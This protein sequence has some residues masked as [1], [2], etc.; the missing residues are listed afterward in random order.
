MVKLK[1]RSETIKNIRV[2]G[3]LF[4]V[5]FFIIGFRGYSLQILSA[6]KLSKIIKRQTERNIELSP[7]RGTIYD[8]NGSELS[9]SIDV[10]SL[11]ANPHLIDNKGLTAIK[12]SRIL[13]ISHKTILKNFKKNR[14]FVWIKRQIS[15]AEASKIKKLGINGLEFVAE[16]QRFYPNKELGAQMIGFVG[17]DPKGL[18]GI[19]YEY[20]DVLKGKSRYLAINRDALGR[21]L[22]IDGAK[23]SEEVQ[24]NDITLTIDKNIQ[25]IAEKELQAAISISKAKS[26]IA[27]VMEPATGK[28]LAMA[29]APLFNPNQYKKY[30]PKTWRNRAITD[31]FEP[32]STFKTFLMASALEE[33]I[34]KPKDIFFCENGSF[35]VANRVIHDTHPHGWL[36][37]TKILKYSSNIG[38]SKIARH[39]GSELFY[40]HIREFGFGEETGIA[41]PSEANG[42]IPLPYRTSEH[43]RSAMAFGQG[44]SVSPLQL[45][46]AYSA[47][48]NGGL[49]M[50]PYFVEKITHPNGMT[51]QETKPQILRRVVTEKTARTVRNML[52]TVVSK[53]GTG[54]KARTAS[55]NVAGK[56][57]TSQKID[58]KLKTYSSQKLIA[59]FAGFAPADDPAITVLVIID[60]PEKLMSGGAIAAP[61]FS[62]I[63][64]QTLNYLHITPDKQP[65]YNYENW[66]EANNTAQRNNVSG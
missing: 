53:D 33:N 21:Q 44:I 63:T 1:N 38:V 26:G 12:I 54:E 34:I 37:A 60:E 9:V 39:L 41:F 5:F 2:I 11:F 20:N 50:K 22:F 31:E 8:R 18:E 65:Q 4:I 49:Y 36:N 42:S 10:E 16:S 24:G 48:A 43:T 28:V 6:E 46:T 55:Y 52:K 47:I 3:L 7:K 51:I 14:R 25:Y 13:G 32:G 64:S 62:R 40:Q 61:T 29:V 66:Q 17:D 19:E 58:K 27:I 15:P 56:T 30:E 59:S 57:G 23:T 35:R 45:A